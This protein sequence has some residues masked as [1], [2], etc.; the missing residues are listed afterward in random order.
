MVPRASSCL[1]V[2]GRPLYA[3]PV[4]FGEDI[5]DH[6]FYAD[7]LLL[8]EGDRDIRVVSLKLDDRGVTAFPF[9][10]SHWLLLPFGVSDGVGQSLDLPIR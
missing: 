9:L 1:G 10:D 2:W 5:E 3:L 6:G 8:A 7:A 4:G